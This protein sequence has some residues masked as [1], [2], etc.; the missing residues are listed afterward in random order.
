MTEKQLHKQISKQEKI[1]KKAKR[2]L[3]LLKINRLGYMLSFWLIIP[4]FL[5]PGVNRKIA[6][7]EQRIQLAE[8]V[9]LLAEQTLL[10]Q[11]QPSE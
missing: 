11:R 7:L 2:D 8:Q 5:L 1:I 3:R 6:A 10:A 9:I 4:L